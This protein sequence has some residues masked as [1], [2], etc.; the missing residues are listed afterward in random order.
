MIWI[1]IIFLKIYNHI[2]KWAVC[3][4][5]KIFFFYNFI[6]INYIIVGCDILYQCVKT[7]FINIYNKHKYNVCRNVFLRMWILTILNASMLI[8][9]FQLYLDF[10]W[11]YLVFLEI[12]EIEKMFTWKHF[13]RYVIKVY[14]FYNIIEIT[15]YRENTI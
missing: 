8:I 9:Y 13:K 14:I 10:W 1:D 3:H 5:K 12:S 4:L 2:E 7:I 15:Y 6:M 11:R